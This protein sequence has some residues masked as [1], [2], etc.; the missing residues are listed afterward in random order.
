MQK[1]LYIACPDTLFERKPQF[2]VG[3]YL[4]VLGDPPKHV[5]VKRSGISDLIHI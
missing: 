4:T 5:L 1:I 2:G 3:G